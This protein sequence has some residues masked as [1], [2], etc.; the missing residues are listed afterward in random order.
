[1][2]LAVDAQHLARRIDQGGGVVQLPCHH[3][4]VERDDEHELQRSGRCSHAIDGCAIERFGEPLIF[5]G[6]LLREKPRCEHLLQAHD[7]GALPCRLLQE[8]LGTVEILLSVH[9][10]LH[11]NE[12]CSHQRL[13]VCG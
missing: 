2:V 6:Q 3:A 10:C 7:F 12:G 4:L 1:V 11:L 5:R 8:L 13:S 9:G